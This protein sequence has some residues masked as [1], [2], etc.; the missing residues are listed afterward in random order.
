[1]KSRTTAKTIRIPNDTYDDI[2][3]EAEKKEL[4]FREKRMSV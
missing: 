4:L 1:M 2:K 3:R